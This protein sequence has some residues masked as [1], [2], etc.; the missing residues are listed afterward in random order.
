MN[1][2]S[3]ALDAPFV[4][5]ETITLESY[6]RQVEADQDKEPIHFVGFSSRSTSGMG[7]G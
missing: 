2:K 6:W 7:E 1:K 3:K 4:Q 5:V